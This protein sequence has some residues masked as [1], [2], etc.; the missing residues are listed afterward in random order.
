MFE[1]GTSHSTV[2]VQPS[3]SDKSTSRFSRRQ[4]VASMRR[5]QIVVRSSDT[6][7]GFGLKLNFW[8]IGYCPKD[9]CQAGI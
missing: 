8:V 9:L 4:H 1:F 7:C 3:V 5:W 2:G 6:R